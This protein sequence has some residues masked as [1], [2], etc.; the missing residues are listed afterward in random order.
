M[1]RN[2]EIVKQESTFVA[3]QKTITKNALSKLKFV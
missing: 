3:M 1:Y 2:L